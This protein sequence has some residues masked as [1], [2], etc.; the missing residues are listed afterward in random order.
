MADAKALTR[1]QQLEPLSL[2]AAAR[3]LLEECQMV[4]PGIQALFGFQLV[5]GLTQRFGEVLT[6]GDRRLHVAAV[7]FV[8]TAAAK[9]LPD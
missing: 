8:V 9:P 2:D 5:A 3:H 4:L 1:D 7:L 6:D